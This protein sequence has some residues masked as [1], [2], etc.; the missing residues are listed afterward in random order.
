[1][2]LPLVLVNYLG[3]RGVI[4]IEMLL[5]NPLALLAI[6]VQLGI[7]RQMRYLLSG[8]TSFKHQ[9]LFVH[10]IVT[11]LFSFYSFP[12]EEAEDPA[13]IP[14]YWV[15]KWVDYSDKYGLGYQLCDNSVGVL[16]ND[17][18]RLILLS[19]GE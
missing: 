8:K 4:L 17:S 18:T 13:A 10:L 12:T 6:H 2:K 1:M 5:T 7:W 15:S 16:F 19:N 14:I 3:S 9:D 11:H